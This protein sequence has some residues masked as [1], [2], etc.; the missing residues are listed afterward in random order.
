MT[1]MKT[2]LIPELYCAYKTRSGIHCI[3]TFKYKCG[4][5]EM[6]IVNSSLVRTYDKF[7]LDKEER[8]ESNCRN[9][10]ITGNCK[11]Y[12]ELVNKLTFNNSNIKAAMG[13]IE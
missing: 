11:T 3:C 6:H 13:F 7:Y 8:L 12:F 10:W 9:H 2:P 4:S 5:S 1:I